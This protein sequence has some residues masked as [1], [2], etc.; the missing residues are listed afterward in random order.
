MR[1]RRP[2]HVALRVPDVPAAI[3]FYTRV[4]RLSLTEEAAGVAYLRSCFEHHCLELH[5]SDRAGV[6][7]FGWETDSDD[8]TEALRATL[9]AQAVVVRDVAPEPGRRG[10]AFQF[11]DSLG[12]WNE[13]Y[14][15]MDRL[16]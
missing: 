7:H 9:V 14:R 10:A 15:G 4:V 3:D 16:A 6:L 5:P 13:V 11:Q 2:G 1:I 8:D 12:M